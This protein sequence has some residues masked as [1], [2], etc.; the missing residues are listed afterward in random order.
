MKAV[1]FIKRMDAHQEEEDRMCKEVHTQ[2]KNLCGCANMVVFDRKINVDY[3]DYGSF[4]A[5]AV[6]NNVLMARF[7]NV[8]CDKPIQ[9]Y[10]ANVWRFY[11]MLSRID[12]GAYHLE[13]NPLKDKKLTVCV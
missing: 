2:L 6:C 4:D 11:A 13:D 3:G 5:V 10:N 12:N 1:D 9:P 8:W 7:E